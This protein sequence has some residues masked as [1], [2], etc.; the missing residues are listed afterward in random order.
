MLLRF[1]NIVIAKD[2]VYIGSM[3]SNSFRVV[4]A[5]RVAS[6]RTAIDDKCTHTPCTSRRSAFA[7]WSDERCRDPSMEFRSHNAQRKT[8]NK[9]SK[10]SDRFKWNLIDLLRFAKYGKCRATDKVVFYSESMMADQSN[11]GMEAMPWVGF[12]TIVSA[13]SIWECN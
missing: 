10:P 1:Y 7:H 2:L 8:P 5:I 6:I 4:A 9:P 13:K 3:G 12:K 11:I